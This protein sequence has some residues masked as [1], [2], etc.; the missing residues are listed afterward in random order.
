MIGLMDRSHFDR[1]HEVMMDTIADASKGGP[2][3]RKRWPDEMKRR[4]VAETLEPGA[5]VSVVARRHDVNANQVFTWRRRY[6]DGLPAGDGEARAMIPVRIAPARTVSRPT[7]PPAAPVPGPV[8]APVR[9]GVVEIELRGGVRV[10]IKGAVDGV[11]LREVL[12]LLSRR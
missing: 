1:V 3:R 6:R 8:S 5:S 4:I 2:A 10:R 9:P 12:L 11:A 7:R